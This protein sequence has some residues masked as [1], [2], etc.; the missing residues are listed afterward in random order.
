VKF[1][2]QSGHFVTI[3]GTKEGLLFICDDQCDFVDL[4]TEIKGKLNDSFNKFI[5]DAVID[6]VIRL[7]KRQVSEEQKLELTA[8]VGAR[9]NINVKAIEADEVEMMDPR[10]LQLIDHNLSVHR[11]TIRSG[12]VHK[13]DGN[14]LLLGDV[15]PG[16]S[17]VVTG[18]LYVMGA[19]RGMAHAGSEGNERSVIVAS[20]MYPAQLRIAT[21]ISRPPDE[22]V[23][24]DAYMEFAYLDGEQMKLDKLAN[25]HRRK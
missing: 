3:K 20:H 18:D 11:G 2:Q 23:K 1:V 24:E 4:M 15:N 6:A 25:M 9:P 5:D 10:I 13:H 7:G 17:V 19:L 21:V 16:G 22:W 12:Q 8:I 14:L